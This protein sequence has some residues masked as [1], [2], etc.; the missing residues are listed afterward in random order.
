MCAGTSPYLLWHGGEGLV[1]GGSRGTRAGTLAC[2][3]RVA[4][5]GHGRPRVHLMRCV[6][7]GDNEI[8][9]VENTARLADTSNSVASNS[10][11]S[12]TAAIFRCIGHALTRFG[13]AHYLVH[14]N[15]GR[16]RPVSGHPSKRGDILSVGAA[17]GSTMPRRVPDTCPRAMAPEPATR[18]SSEGKCEER[19]A[20]QSH[21]RPH[22]SWR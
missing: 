12:S 8:E 15:V 4:L 14:R 20:Y 3:C 11:P 18:P 22:G 1:A 21:R 2:A 17:S 16:Q 13:P 5:R 10:V 7:G 6:V 19:N 9:A